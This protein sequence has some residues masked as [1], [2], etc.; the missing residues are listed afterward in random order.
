MTDIIEKVTNILPRYGLQF[1]KKIYLMFI[2][3]NNYGT[4]LQLHAQHLTYYTR[5]TQAR[6]SIFKA[7]PIINHK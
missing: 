3:V 4:I 5:H 6:D 2:N 7:L 1:R